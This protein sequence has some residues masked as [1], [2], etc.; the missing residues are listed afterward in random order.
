MQEALAIPTPTIVVDGMNVIGARAR[1]W[2]RDPEGAK[3]SLLDRLFALPGP[4]V[5]VLDGKPLEG[6]EEGDHRG[7]RLLYARR[8]G[9]DA[10]DDRIVELVAEEPGSYLVVTSDRALRD[11]VS[12]LGAEV[13][14]ASWLW[15][16]LEP[17]P[18]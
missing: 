4:I 18:Q 17:S 10:A 7:V 5:L 6:L 12:T 9:R 15:E 2:W 3:R 1:G 8:P 13:R 16:R 11:R 14:G